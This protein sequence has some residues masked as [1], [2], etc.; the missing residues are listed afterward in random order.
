[1]DADL[2]GDGEGALQGAGRKWDD[3]NLQIAHMNLHPSLLLGTGVEDSLTPKLLVGV[4]RFFLNFIR[5]DWNLGN[6]RRQQI[7]GFGV[8]CGTAIN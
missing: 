4:T 3:N 5:L 8:G 6:L 1:M 2:R 7:P